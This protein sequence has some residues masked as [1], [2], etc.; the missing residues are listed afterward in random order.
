MTRRVGGVAGLSLGPSD[1]PAYHLLAKSAE[2]RSAGTEC[3]D[4][5]T[6]H[7]QDGPSVVPPGDRLLVRLARGPTGL[8]DQGEEEQG[9]RVRPV[10]RDPRGRAHA[11][12]RTGPHSAR[13]GRGV[14]G[15]PQGPDQAG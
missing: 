14:Q 11:V 5:C 13:A 3:T 7:A 9:G 8:P 1:W 4:W 15:T 10:R 2:E 6:D 12:A